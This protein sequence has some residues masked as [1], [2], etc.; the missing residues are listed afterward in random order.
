MHRAQ[1]YKQS[2]LEHTKAAWTRCLLSMLLVMH[3]ISKALGHTRSIPGAQPP[4]ETCWA[5]LQVSATAVMHTCL[6][7]AH[8]TLAAEA[9]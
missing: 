9:Q 5:A 3:T 8:D 2:M 6:A 4:Q 1:Q 7:P